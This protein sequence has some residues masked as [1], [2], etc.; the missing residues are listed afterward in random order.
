MQDIFKGFVPRESSE[1]IQ[2]VWDLPTRF[3]VVDKSIFIPAEVLKEKDVMGDKKDRQPVNSDRTEV[4]DTIKAPEER[5]NK[6]SSQDRSQDV[7]ITS[8]RT[9]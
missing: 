8:E 7:Q 1:L 3:T 4:C 5:E 9:R 2:K 6:N